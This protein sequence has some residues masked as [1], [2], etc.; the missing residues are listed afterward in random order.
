MEVLSPNELKLMQGLAQEVMALRPELVNGDVTIGELAWV[1]AKDVDVLS[2]FWRHRL[3][4]VDGR[5]AAWGWA[6]LPYRIARGDGTFRE[7]KAANLL[8]QT[9]PDRPALLNGILDW[10]DDVAGDIDRSLT[11]QSADS[12]AQAIVSAHGFAFDEETGGADDGSWIQFNKRELTDLPNPVL[13]EGFL[14]LTAGDVSVA[15]AVKAH[16]DAWPRSTFTETA[17]ER[18][19]QTWPYRADLHALIKAPGGT[20]VAS[21]IIWFDDVTRTAEFEPVGTHPDFR[22][23]GLGTALQLHGMHL[24]KAAG[25]EQMLVACLG[26]AAHPAAR[27]MYYGVGFRPFTRDLPQIKRAG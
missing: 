1:W 3:W 5:L 23:Q 25:A 19:R 10:Y 12:A 15:Q 21:A 17:F 20:L 8:W 4:F 16:R 2:P 11:L 7:T 22:R 9:H 13:P 24:A 18:V 14:F 26:A 6:H 27:N